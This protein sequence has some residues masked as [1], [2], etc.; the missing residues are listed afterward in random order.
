[1]SPDRYAKPQPSPSEEM[2]RYISLYLMY[3]LVILAVIL[4][5]VAVVRTTRGGRRS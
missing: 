4:V 2:L 3:G 1:M 5:V